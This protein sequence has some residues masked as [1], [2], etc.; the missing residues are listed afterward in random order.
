MKKHTRTP[1]A[2]F[3]ADGYLYYTGRTVLDLSATWQLSRHLSLVGTFNN[4]TNRHLRWLRYGEA[5]P[6]Y[7]RQWQVHDYSALFTVGLSGKF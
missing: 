4:A 2:G 5:T 7:A 3:G 6:H 1:V